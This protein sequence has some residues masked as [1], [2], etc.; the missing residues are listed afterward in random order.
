M[1]KIFASSAWGEVV[2]ICKENGALHF[3]GL[4]SDGNVHSNIS[5]LIAMIKQAKKD[6]VKSVKVHALL[7]GRDVP[8]TSA[9]TYVE[10]LESAMAELNDAS[11]NAEIASGGGRM[12]VTMDRY[13]ADWE[14]VKR[15][16]E[17]HV[18]GNARGFASATEAIN[19]FRA[20]NN[21]IIDQD[22]PAFVVERNGAPVGAMKDGDGVT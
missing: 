14:M 20:E 10:T 8:A 11:F 12:K 17:T 21:G 18:H 6:G 22:L 9:L 3:V 16:W 1:E 19:T 4:L 7:D 2:G 5:H 15:G 13:R